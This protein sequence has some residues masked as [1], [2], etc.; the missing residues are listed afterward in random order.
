MPRSVSLS[1]ARF[2][3]TNLISYQAL[4]S[5][6]WLLCQITISR[7]SHVYLDV[8]YVDIKKAFDSVPD[9]EFPMKLCKMG[10]VGNI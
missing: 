6:Y 8:L 9:C 3:T 2:P 10:L 4:C 1:S 7:E 5:I